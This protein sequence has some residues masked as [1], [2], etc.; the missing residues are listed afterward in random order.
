MTARKRPD[1]EDFRRFEA[2]FAGQLDNLRGHADER[3][4]S[5]EEVATAYFRLTEEDPPMVAHEDLCDELE[6]GWWEAWEV[7]K[8]LTDF[9]EV[10]LSWEE[11]W[12]WVIASQVLAE[13][14]DQRNIGLKQYL[15]M[16][17]DLQEFQ[18]DIARWYEI[19]NMR[20]NLQSRTMRE[21]KVEHGQRLQ[22]THYPEKPFNPDALHDHIVA[23]YMKTAQDEIVRALDLSY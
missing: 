15:D 23:R 3:G 13:A 22:E 4:V 14:C 20:G 8:V 6:L 18:S 17:E 10:H 7:G 16:R 1:E 5:L 12:W 11:G 9:G 19:R 21:I 2:L